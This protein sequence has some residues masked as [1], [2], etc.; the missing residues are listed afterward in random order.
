MITFFAIPRRFVGEFDGLQR[1][2]FRSW[3]ASAPGSQVILFGDEPGTSRAV[4]EL[5]LTQCLEIDYNDMGRPLSDKPFALAERYATHQ[6]LCFCSADVQ[7]NFDAPALLARLADVER[8]FVIGR[9]YDL[10]AGAHPSTATLHYAGG[11]DYFLFRRGTIGPT[12][13]FAVS[14]GGGDQWFVYK[15]LTAWHM[16]VIDA[17]DAIRATHVNHAHP[18]WGNGKAGREGSPEQIANRR[19]LKADGMTRGYTVNDAPLV[20]SATQELTLRERV[21]A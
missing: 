8:P 13:P 15:A 7:L 3:Q 4:R 18:E 2:A 1:N 9:R 10:T 21:V 17:T 11:I 6:W 5:G 12:L 16:S 19:L 20:L 14:G